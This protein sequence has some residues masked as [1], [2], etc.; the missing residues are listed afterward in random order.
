MEEY[1]TEQIR[2]YEELEGK[3]SREREKLLTDRDE[4]VVNGIKITECLFRFDRKL[5]IH[6]EGRDLDW[7]A[8]ALS[9]KR[10]LEQDVTDIEYDLRDITE[11]LS[12]VRKILTDLRIQLHRLGGVP[13]DAASKALAVGD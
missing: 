5:K 3:L 9:S 7:Y 2:S 6:G 1:L 4:A 11:R 12:N 13:H 8:R 10:Y